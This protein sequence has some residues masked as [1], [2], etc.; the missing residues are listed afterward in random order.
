MSEV[1]TQ[2][3]P[4]VIRA[5]WV[6]KLTDLVSD[7][8]NWATAD[9]WAVTRIEKK[10]ADSGIGPYKAP[11]LVFQKNLV[12]LLL[13][14]ISREFP[15]AEGVVDLYR[16]PA[17]DDV[18]SVYSHKGQWIINFVCR[19]K[20]VLAQVDEAQSTPLTAESFAEVVA[21]MI[22]DGS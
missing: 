13:D 10:M 3:D 21:G 20:N 6:T 7:I 5:E 22:A 14:P 17:L 11:A 19:N 9:G 18:A 1:E 15:G 2:I 4:A 12:R 16:M 8:E